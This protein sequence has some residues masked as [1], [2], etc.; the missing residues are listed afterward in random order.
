MTRAAKILLFLGFALL[1]LSLGMLLLLHFGDTKAQEDAETLLQQLDILLPP[2]TPGVPDTYR[3]PVMPTLEVGGRDV[4]AIVEIPAFGLRLPVLGSWEAGNALGIPR[5]FSGSA[6][7]GD[8]IIGG[9]AAQF[10]CVAQ[11]PAGTQVTVTDMTGAV[12]SYTVSRIGRST[13]ADTATLSGSSLTLF[14]RQ[15]HSLE[16]ILLRCD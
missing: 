8:L 7:S 14:A 15:T 13:S 5:R 2:P 1:A 3:V 9:S 6:Y 4:V 12:F 11:I 16:Y 10:A